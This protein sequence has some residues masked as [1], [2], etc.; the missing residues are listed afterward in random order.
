MKKVFNYLIFLLIFVPT[1]SALGIAPSDTYISFEPYGSGSFEIMLINNGNEDVNASVNI[2]GPFAEYFIMTDGTQEVKTGSSTKYIVGYSFPASL[3]PHGPI[4]HDLNVRQKVNE[5]QQGISA[6]LSV[7]AR[8]VVDVPYPERYLEYGLT[9][10]DIN[11]GEDLNFNFNVANKG[12][13]NIFGFKSNLIIYDP[14]SEEKL[15]ELED[16]PSSLISG[17][18]VTKT[19]SLDS[20]V[21]GGGTFIADSFIIYD[22]IETDHK[23]ITFKVGY[24]DI[25]VIEYPINATFG[26]IRKLM[27]IVDNKWNIAINDVV[28]ETHI[29][30][31]GVPVTER[32][33][34]N[35]FDLKALGEMNVP[36]YLDMANVN[37]GKYQLV[38]TIKYNGA[39]KVQ[40]FDF[41][42]ISDKKFFTKEM[43]TVI[44]IVFLIIANVIWLILRKKGHISD[45]KE[46]YFD[47]MDQ[48]QNKLG[49]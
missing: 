40:N 18:K 17:V 11:E 14:S 36:V 26:G 22:G 4:N 45:K 48:L 3:S 42:V 33:I 6:S 43:A 47:K 49:K 39:E 27:F 30:K 15:F 8:V 2:G 5:A 25:E 32:S 7:I 28:I 23:N 29:E 9:V 38:V 46:D 10:E 16:T 37:T 19:I 1:I 20:S 41:S 13:G 44:L 31:N 24:E 21:I 34:S 35:G 12:E